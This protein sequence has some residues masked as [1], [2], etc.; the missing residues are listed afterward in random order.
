MNKMEYEKLLNENKSLK[1]IIS[2]TLGYE[3]LGYE[4]KE[5]LLNV[6]TVED[7]TLENELLHARIQQLDVKL[8]IEI[9]KNKGIETRIQSLELD[10]LQLK[11]ET[12][13]FKE[14]IKELKSKIQDMKLKELY[15]QFIIAIQDINHYQ[16]LQSKLKS[17]YKNLTKLRYSHNT[18][19]HYVDESEPEDLMRDRMTV[20]GD[21]LSTM[22]T[23]LRSKFDMEFPN[24]IQDLINYIE[25]LKTIPSDDNLEII[26]YFWDNKK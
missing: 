10:N 9:Q 14:E 5:D 21:K 17:H 26:S 8:D 13:F 11:Y 4:Y 2:R 3:S 23:E 6:L 20:L 25:P 12:I 19:C 18:E 1:L 22:N 15:N 24:L 16:D 7:L